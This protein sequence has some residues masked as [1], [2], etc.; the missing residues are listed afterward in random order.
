MAEV[1][2]GNVLRWYFK[3]QLGGVATSLLPWNAEPSA[4]DAALEQLAAVG[5]VDVSRTRVGKYGKNFWVITFTK[6]PGM[7]PP[8][9]GNVADLG[10]VVTLT[11]GGADV[12]CGA[13]CAEARG[14][15]RPSL[16]V[17]ETERG[18][19]S[20]GGKFDLDFKSN[21]RGAKRMDFDEDAY[22][23]QLK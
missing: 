12:P 1:R 9:T 14:L 8:G 19:E 15:V 21:P 6:N 10:T 13:P 16:V 5:N 18:S 3:L 11:E 4:V 20:L 23:V 22:R 17:Q 2:R 7:T